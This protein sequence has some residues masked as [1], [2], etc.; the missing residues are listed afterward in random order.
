VVVSHD[1][2]GIHQNIPA[3]DKSRHST[4]DQLNGAAARKKTGHEPEDNQHPQ[5]AEEIGHP[6]REVVF[7]LAGEEG[8]G[9]E[10]AKREDECFDDDSRFVE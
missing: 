5:R 10:D 4:I 3:K 6:A 9:D 8:Q 2:L 1:E 7:G